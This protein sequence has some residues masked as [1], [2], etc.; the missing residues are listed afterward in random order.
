MIRFDCFDSANRSTTSWKSY[1]SRLV[2]FGSHYEMKILGKSDIT[3]IFGNTS[4]GYFIYFPEH[5]TGFNI[6]NTTEVIENA[7]KL[8]SIFENV[9]A[10]TVAYGINTASRLIGGNQKRCK[11]SKKSTN[12]IP[13]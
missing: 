6:P 10:V 4:S 2:Y 1:I 7:S 3:V 12:V 13:F 5:E 9:D 11:R 8:M